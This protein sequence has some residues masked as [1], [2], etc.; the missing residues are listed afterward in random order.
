MQPIILYCTE[1][2]GIEDLIRDN[3]DLDKRNSL[4]L[5]ENIV[6]LGV[7]RSA[8]SSVVLAELGPFRLSLSSL[9]LSI[10]LC[11]H[12]FQFNKNGILKANL[13][14]EHKKKSFGSNFK[15]FIYPIGIAHIWGHQSTVTETNLMKAI[16]LALHNMYVDSGEITCIMTK[17]I[18]V[19]ID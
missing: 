7:N 18:P 5:P 9:K 12:L 10:G 3:T 15:S 1:L 17:A 16:S 13:E 4:Y 2:T 6:V 11:L 14:S 19:V 8:V